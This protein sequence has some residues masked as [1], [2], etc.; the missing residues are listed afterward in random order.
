MKRKSILSIVT[1][2]VAAMAV[3]GWGVMLINT[4]SVEATP[5]QSTMTR[6]LTAVATMSYANWSSTGNYA[7][8]R[9]STT[10][11]WMDWSQDGCS[12][13]PGLDLGYAPRTSIGDVSAM[14]SCGGQWPLRTTVAVGYGTN[15]IAC[16]QTK[17]S[18]RTILTTRAQYPSRETAI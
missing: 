13:P 1:L 5:T 11:E 17:N 14:I 8:L 2:L 15:A 9:D 7:S 12:A 10:Y 3:I 16:L 4:P 6:H 18:S